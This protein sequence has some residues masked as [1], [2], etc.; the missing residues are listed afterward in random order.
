METAPIASYSASRWNREVKYTLY[1]DYIRIIERDKFG[2]E[3]D[4]PIKL[5]DLQPEVNVI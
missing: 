3:V 1:E 4:L 5:T 2:D